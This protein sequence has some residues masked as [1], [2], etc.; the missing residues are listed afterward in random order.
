MGPLLTARLLMLNEAVLAPARLRHFAGQIEC[1]LRSKTGALNS[2][3][4]S[5]G[6][7]G[8]QPVCEVVTGPPAT[9]WV[10]VELGGILL[11]HRC[12][13]NRGVHAC[14]RILY[15]SLWIA[16]G[17][18]ERVGRRRQGEGKH[19]GWDLRGGTGGT[20]STHRSF[21]GRRLCYLSM[22]DWYQYAMVILDHPSASW[23]R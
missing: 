14:P 17:I 4:I 13:R 8:S 12:G 19:G 1:G 9:S 2:K 21:G 7:K 22:P 20:P 3:P 6:G 16:E 18:H 23:A 11:Q 10:G 15:S 5:H